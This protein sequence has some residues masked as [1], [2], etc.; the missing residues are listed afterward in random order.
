MRLWLLKV[1]FLGIY[2][3]GYLNIEGIPGRVEIILYV[4]GTMNFN[5]AVII[6]DFEQ[7][8]V[9]IT[10]VPEVEEGVSV[11]QLLGPPSHLKILFILPDL[12]LDYSIFSHRTISFPLP[13]P[14]FLS[15]FRSRMEVWL[16]AP[17]R[18]PTVVST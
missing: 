11:V 15:V 10:L 12:Q 8:K 9:G 13:C 1:L 16:L 5:V 18:F 4:F 17:I 14:L 3:S 6:S 7:A 2:E